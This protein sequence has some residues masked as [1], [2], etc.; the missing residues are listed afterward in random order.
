MAYSVSIEYLYLTNLNEWKGFWNKAS[1]DLG[2]L[3][4]SLLTKSHS[5]SQIFLSAVTEHSAFIQYTVNFTYIKTLHLKQVQPLLLNE[6]E[7][8]YLHF[9]QKMQ[10]VKD[11]CNQMTLYLF[12]NNL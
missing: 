2:D 10:F 12:W 8:S 7:H 6:E 3:R 4:S 5:L 1:A 9:N 11:I